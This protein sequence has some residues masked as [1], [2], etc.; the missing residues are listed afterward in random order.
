MIELAQRAIVAHG[1]MAL[2]E[3]ADEITVELSAGGLAFASKLQGSAVR[4]TKVRISTRA[5]HVVFEEFPR[6]GRRGV[7]EPDGSVRIE[8]NDGEV[9]Q[10]RANPRGEFADIRH[11]LWWDRLDML[12][13]ATY[14]IWTY[15]ATPFVFA[16]D[17][18]ELSAAGTWVE[19]GESWERLSVRFPPSVQTHSAEQVFYIDERGLIR[20]HD[21]TA[22]PLAS[23]AKAAHYCMDHETFDGL[24]GPDPPTCL[25][26]AGPTTSAGP[27]RG[28]SGST[29]RPQAS[30][31]EPEA[32]RQFRGP[33][34]REERGGRRAPCPNAVRG[35]RARGDRLGAVRSGAGGDA[36][37]ASRPRRSRFAAP[38]VRGDHP[39]RD[40]ASRPAR[41]HPG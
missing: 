14:A 39:V 29:S 10:S 15:V 27:T 34:P 5:Q 23:W 37:R 3:E 8:T 40:R 33:G 38:A 6:E 11:R 4:A 13:F 24:V 22:E 18:Y 36:V 16:Q 9:L 12:Y 35:P 19:D 26:R 21:Y 28:S 31:G 7:L 17:G 25:S 32:R 20:R 30:W 1:G 41:A 2:W